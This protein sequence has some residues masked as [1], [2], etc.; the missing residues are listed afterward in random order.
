MLGVAAHRSL[1]DLA[2]ALGRTGRAHNP[3]IDYEAVEPAKDICRAQDRAFYHK[4]ITLSNKAELQFCQRALGQLQ[5]AGRTS[6][7]EPI[8]V[9]ADCRHWIEMFEE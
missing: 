6:A 2:Q 5:E 8:R 3:R 1:Q 7:I 9:D 4:L